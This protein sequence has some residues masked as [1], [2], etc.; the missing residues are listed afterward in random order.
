MKTIQKRLKPI[1]ID[2]H[3]KYECPHCSAIHWLTLKETQT[4]GFI[5]VCEC[6]NVLR[7]QTVSKIKIAYRRKTKKHKTVTQSNDVDIVGKCAK[8]LINYGFETDE[9]T[10]LVEK[11]ITVSKETDVVKIIKLCLSIFGE[12]Q[13][14]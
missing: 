6:N 14:G 12:N 3:L 13:H 10:A 7:V 1:D 2:T 9:A 11:A 8:I 4:K 5:I